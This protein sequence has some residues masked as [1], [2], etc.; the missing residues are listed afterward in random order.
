MQI[1]IIYFSKFGNTRR[2][3]EAIVETMKQAGQTRVVS[4]DQLRP[5]DFGGVDLV[6]LGSPT[7]AFSV[8]PVVRSAL[9]DLPPG[10]LAGKSVAAFDTT[11]RPWP[12]RLMRASPKLLRELSRLGGKPIARPQTFFVK[13]SGTQQAPETDLLLAGQIDRAREW[14]S[15][16]LGQLRA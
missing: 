3:A 15:Q 16:L 2:V 11:V 12:L 8:P 13:T 10:I 9:A 5:A 4:I 6:V 1:L 7:H 14:A